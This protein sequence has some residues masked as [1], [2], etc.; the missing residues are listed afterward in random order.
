MDLIGIDDLPFFRLVATN[1][2]RLGNP[3]M[4]DIVDRA[5]ENRAFHPSQAVSIRIYRSGEDVIREGEHFD[6][7]F[8]ALDGQVRIIQR[9]RKIR[10]LEPRDVFGLEGV[11]LKK[12]SPY[13]ARTMG[14]TRI[15]RYGPDALDHFIRQNPR[16]T[17]DILASAVTQL[18]QTSHNLSMEF[19]SFSLEDVRI[20]FFEDGAVILEEGTTGAEFFRLV[21]SQGGL[22][23]SVKGGE[24][25]RIDK[26]GEFFG[27]LAALLKLPRLATVTSIGESAVQMYRMDDLDIILKDYPEIALQIIRKLTVRPIDADSPLHLA[28]RLI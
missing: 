28:E 4:S 7:F 17:R 14:K 5:D 9:G 6:G 22:S 25:A 24:V 16:M 15:A 20:D 8:V 18:M 10:L 19:N 2:L 1:S 21:S 12:P 23:V 3:S 11:L 27:E 13:V 26:P